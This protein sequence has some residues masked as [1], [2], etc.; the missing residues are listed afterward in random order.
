MLYKVFAKLRDRNSCS[1]RGRS[2][3]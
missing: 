2:C 3:V 1:L